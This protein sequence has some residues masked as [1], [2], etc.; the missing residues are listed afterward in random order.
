MIM[1]CREIEDKLECQTYAPRGEMSHADMRDPAEILI[2]LGCTG[3]D[4]L[5]LIKIFF[6]FECNCNAVSDC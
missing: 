5:D 3:A 2:M 4:M 1:L 6:S